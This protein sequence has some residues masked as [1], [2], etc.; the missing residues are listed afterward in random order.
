MW[1]EQTFGVPVE[2]EVYM[3]IAVSSGVGDAGAL[4]STPTGI[5]ESTL[6]P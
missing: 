1:W 2:P 5:D 3:I 4:S 6:A